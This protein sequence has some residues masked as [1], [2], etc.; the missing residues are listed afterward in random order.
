MAAQSTHKPRILCTEDDID[1]RDLLSFALNLEGY[2][3]VCTSSPVETLKRAQG[4]RFDLFIVDNWLPGMSGRELTE[5]LR[6]FDLE[7]PILFY[8]GAAQP[9]DKEDARLAGA[10]GYLVKPAGLDDLIAEVERLIAGCNDLVR[11]SRRSS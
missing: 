4:E 11:T 8:S 2:E 3:V 9:T 5:A 7:T 6:K 10:Q 1:T